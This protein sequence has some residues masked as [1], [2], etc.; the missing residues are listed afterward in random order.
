MAPGR[1]SLH[2]LILVLLGL[3]ASMAGQEPPRR[4]SLRPAVGAEVGYSRSDLGGANAQR[5]ESRQGALT[6]VYLQVPLKPPVFLRTEVLFALKGGRTQAVVDSGAPRDLDIGL[7]YIEVPVLFRLAATRGRFRPVVFGGP[8]PSLQIGC[9]LQVIDPN[10]P[11]RATCAASDVPPFRQFDIGL[12]GGGGVEIR[13]PQSALALEARY[14]A[15][16]RSVLPGITARN[17]AFGVVLALTF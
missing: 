2:L 4:S 13:W 10:T 7:A 11:I 9:D 5:V 14:T 6:G 12:V 17:R 16:L 1:S 3:P 15:G 8:A